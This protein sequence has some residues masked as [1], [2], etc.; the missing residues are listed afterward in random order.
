VHRQAATPANGVPH[1]SRRF[2]AQTPAR[3]RDAL[4]RI[5]VKE[6]LR[7]DEGHGA[8]ECVV[9]CDGAADAE[10]IIKVFQPR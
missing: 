2:A 5:A 7:G 6:L 4:L 9:Q 3:A 8:Y 1:G 10:G